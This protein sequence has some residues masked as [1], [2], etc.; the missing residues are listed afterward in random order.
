M[1]YSVLHL[2]KL[3]YAFE[4]LKLKKKKYKTYTEMIF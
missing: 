3:A 4:T 2:Y 1:L